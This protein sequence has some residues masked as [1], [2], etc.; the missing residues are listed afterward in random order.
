MAGPRQAN[1]VSLTMQPGIFTQRSNRQSQARYIDGENV[2]W[3][4][5][6]AQ[7]MGGYQEILLN[8]TNGN[9]IWYY[10][11]VRGVKQWDSLDGQS[12]IAFGTEYKLYVI[13]NGQLYDITPLRTTNT[14]INGF[15]ITAGQLVVTVVDDNHGANVG[16]FVNYSGFTPV[17]NVNLNAE[18]QVASV[19]DLNTYTIL[20]QF[21]ASNTI[22]NGGGT[23]TAAYDWPSGLTDDGALTGFGV[24]Q[25]SA[26]P[27][28]TP[29][30]NSTFGGY[31]RIWS[32]DNWGEDLLASPNG[33]AL[34]WWQR[35]S[36]PNSRAVIRPTAPQNSERMLVGP[37]DRHV[38]LLGTNVDAADLS[39][40]TGQ[41][42][43]MF[44]RWCIGDDFDVWVE[45]TAND[46]GS[47]RADQGSRLIT[48]CKTRT[49]V[50][51]FSD[52]AIYNVALVGGTDVYQ[53]VPLDSQGATIISP[54][55][56]VD[57]QGSVYF[58]GR[59]GFWF[60]NG[61][62]NYL[63]CDI[64]DYVFG[65]K[66]YAGI[67]RN[68]QDKVTCR[69]REDFTEIHWS[70]PS[71]NSDEN[72]STAIYN[73][74]LQCWYISSIAREHGLDTNDFYGV[75]I[76]FNDTGVYAE[77][78]GTDVWT[79]EALFNQLTSW[80]GEL[81]AIGRTD[82]GSN[83]TIWVTSAGSEIMQ[84][85]KIYPDFKEMAGSVTF[86]MRGREL[87]GDPLVYGDELVCLP[88][89]DFLEPRF[90]QRRISIY[91]ESDTVGDFWRMDVLDGTSTAY[92]R[93]G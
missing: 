86:Q 36:G 69:L 30:T 50:L 92:G 83:Q 5:G 77:E 49:A 74:A 56:A 29:R 93:R 48:A 12:W 15:S 87:S 7:K 66:V 90:R 46:A 13:N 84:L 78:S 35:S 31:A 65:S 47:Y 18:F 3:F 88:T 45:T 23:A 38:I 58:M 60:Y 89:T 42:D 17:G 1:K 33:E 51:A 41:Q 21:P 53:F 32:L 2:R 54:N 57:V 76:G 70:F 4:Q 44:A 80:E 9:P 68:M 20:V 73:W 59:K 52:Q 62:V 91:M 6:I 67:N 72:D 40:P 10:G 37:D 79:E 64:L 8:D 26:G 75:P 25:Y 55:A 85:H 16:D 34:F 39:G 43:R 24:G 82:A 28:G 81:S 19:I 11:H 63:P 27:Y 71:N 22:T 61:T 14:I